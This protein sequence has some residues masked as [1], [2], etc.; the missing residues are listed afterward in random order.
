MKRFTFF[1]CL[2]LALASVKSFAEDT[3][4]PT[5][6]KLVSAGDRAADHLT[7]YLNEF[8]EWY[9][10]SREKILQ[11]REKQKS[12]NKRENA[13]WHQRN[14]YITDA[15]SEKLKTSYLKQQSAYDGEQSAPL[16]KD[17]DAD[18][19]TC[20][21]NPADKLLAPVQSGLTQ[22]DKN[23]ATLSVTIPK[24]QWSDQPDNTNLSTADSLSITITLVA[25][26]GS[27]KIDKVTDISGK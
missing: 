19:V 21:L 18:V 26:K 24:Y 5:P 20:L 12:G 4:V 25:E 7:N 8:Y 10:L 27:W 6:P 22:I 11:E 17:H 15:L 14:L 2:F 23:G 9:F 13:S 16:C 3:A 1:I